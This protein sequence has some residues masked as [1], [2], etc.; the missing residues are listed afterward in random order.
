M[1]VLLAVA[2][3]GV[4]SF[5]LGPKV[6]EIE[7]AAS[8]EGKVAALVE[9]IPEKDY[10]LDPRTKTSLCEVAGPLPD[11]ACTPGAVFATTTAET[12]CVTGYTKTVRSVSTKLRKQLFAAYGVSYPPPSGA[13]ELDHLVPLELGGNNDAANLFPEAAAPNPGF[14]D[15][16]VV[17]NYLHDEVCAGRLGLRAAQKQIADDWLSVYRAL[18]QSTID[19]YKQK[20]RSW[21]N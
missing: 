9:A 4:W 15:K 19:F 11:H 2:C 12:I 1:L 3:M 17:E 14:K 6:E 18:D 7:L 8:P 13:Y 5:V 16:D 20:F 21:A 10:S